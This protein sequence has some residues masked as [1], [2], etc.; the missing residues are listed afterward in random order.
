MSIIKAWP[1][2]WCVQQIVPHSGWCTA[3]STRTDVSSGKR[4]GGMYGIRH[5][6]LV[7][8]AGSAGIWSVQCTAQDSGVHDVMPRTC[9]VFDSCQGG[10]GCC[11]ELH[12]WP[13]PAAW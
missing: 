3:E 5:R 11:N 7:C 4:G 6:T 2:L 9:L 8:V 1:S 13:P 12:T 10:L